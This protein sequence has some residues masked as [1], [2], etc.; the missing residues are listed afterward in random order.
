MRVDGPGMKL[1]GAR[2]LGLSL[3][4][5]TKVTHLE[6]LTSAS[7]SPVKSYPLAYKNAKGRVK[8]HESHE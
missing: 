4:N 2:I 5:F 7:V 1:S 3:A 8:I 6:I